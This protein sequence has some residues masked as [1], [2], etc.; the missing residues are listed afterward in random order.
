MLDHQKP[1]SSD[2]E[3]GFYEE[4]D[5]YGELDSYMVIPPST[6]PPPPCHQETWEEPETS[7]TCDIC[8]R[9]FDEPAPCWC[10]YG[11]L[12]RFLGGTTGSLGVVVTSE[13]ARFSA[14][15]SV[16]LVVSAGSGRRWMNIVVKELKKAPSFVGFCA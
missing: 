12:L 6:P 3:L 1:D 13:P 11:A 14:L 8:G 7:K 15:L 16:L 9:R 4:L 5:S 10:I 2:E